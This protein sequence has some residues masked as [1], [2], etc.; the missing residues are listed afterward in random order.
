M[1]DIYYIILYAESKENGWWMV[2]A[3]GFGGYWQ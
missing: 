1:V 3:K 2:L